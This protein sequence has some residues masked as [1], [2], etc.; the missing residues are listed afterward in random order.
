MAYRKV[1]TVPRPRN[2]KKYKNWQWRLFWLYKQYTV[3][4][5]NKE[6]KPQP[7]EQVFKV[8]R[9]QGEYRESIKI[10]QIQEVL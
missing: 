10:L 6:Y 7:F 5:P 9:Q 4:L 3:W 2:K 1:K 8:Y